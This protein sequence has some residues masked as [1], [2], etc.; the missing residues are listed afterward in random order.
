[1]KTAV[2]PVNAG[3]YDLII[4]CLSAEEDNYAVTLAPGKLNI[5]KADPGLEWSVES[6]SIAVGDSVLLYASC[7]SSATIVYTLENIVVA[8]TRNHIEGVHVIGKNEGIT[9]LYITVPESTNHLAYRDSVTFNVKLGAVGNESI[10]LQGVGLYPTLVENNATVVSESPV[11]AIIV[12]DAAG[13][14]QKV[15]NKPEQVIDLSQLRSGYYLVRI[16]LDNGEAKTVRII[17]K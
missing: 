3:S 7:K 13:R 8:G 6:T 12:I 10:T 4:D 15:I 14:I 17:K 16:V 5:A 11:D 9:K 1:M 2:N